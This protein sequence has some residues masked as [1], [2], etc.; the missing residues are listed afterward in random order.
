MIHDGIDPAIQEVFLA[1]TGAIQQ[2]LGLKVI[3]LSDKWAK[4]QFV[5]LVREKGLSLPAQ[6]L[7]QSLS[8]SEG[9][10]LR[11]SGRPK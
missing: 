1:D 2:A 10:Q 4:R 7:V 3:P 11:R 6:S 8:S 9:I 5:I